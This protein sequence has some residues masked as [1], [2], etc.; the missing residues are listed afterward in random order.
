MLSNCIMSK[1]RA[2]TKICD[3]AELTDT[4]NTWRKKIIM[5]I[6]I[7]CY[8]EILTSCQGSMQ[9][10]SK[11]YAKGKTIL[12]KFRKTLQERR[13][14]ILKV[15]LM[16]PGCPK[17]RNTE[18]TLS[19]YSRNI[20]CWLGEVSCS[21]K[22]FNGWNVIAGWLCLMCGT[23]TCVPS[24]S[25]VILIWYHFIVICTLLSILNW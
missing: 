9:T 22:I 23:E 3:C 24:W 13:L 10:F 6:I 2:I 20:A 19:E 11:H 12:V 14:L 1:T 18:G 8:F 25:D 16:F 5:I 17:H 21:V 15:S 4:L 7:L